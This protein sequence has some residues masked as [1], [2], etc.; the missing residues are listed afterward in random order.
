VI[1]ESSGQSSAEVKVSV[2]RESEIRNIFLKSRTD[3]GADDSARNARLGFK[4][5]IEAVAQIASVKYQHKKSFTFARK[6]CIYS[7]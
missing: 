5:F 2:L 6:V 7:L 3:V 4:E 1:D